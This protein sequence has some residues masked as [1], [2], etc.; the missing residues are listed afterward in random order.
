MMSKMFPSVVKGVALFVA[1]YVVFALATFLTL[2]LFFGLDFTSWNEVQ[3]EWF[4][5]LTLTATCLIWLG[6]NVSRQ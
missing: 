3:M 6:D 4:K 5:G 1:Y 2:A